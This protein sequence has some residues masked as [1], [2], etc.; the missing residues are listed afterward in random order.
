MSSLPPLIDIHCHPLPELDDGAASWEE[1]MAMA[2]LAVEDGIACM[3]ATTHQLGA[4]ARIHGDMIRSQTILFQQRLDQQ[5]LPL[6]ILPGAEIRIE[7]DLV[8][9]LQQ[10]ELLSLA[11]R[12]RHV[13]LEL[14]H[15]VYFPIE[16]VLAELKAAGITGILA[17]PERNLAIRA[18][19][20]I[21]AAL[22]RG[23]CLLQVTG[24]SLLGGFGPDVQQFASRLIRQGLV[25]F[26]AT[27]AHGSRARRPLLAKAF[28]AVANLV[29]EAAAIN[30]LSRNPAC[31]AEGRDVA[32]APPSARRPSGGGWL[33]WG[34]AG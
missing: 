30:L 19:P 26:V 7:P 31:V 32:T 2:R 10:G 34:K 4:Y 24:G 21:L 28:Q 33:S 25:H 5:R 18:K 16:R 27:D 8:R 20:E 11:D 13:L 23:G 9:R 1:A 6:K 14:P 17:H 3:V 12:R 22:V 15:D 29:D